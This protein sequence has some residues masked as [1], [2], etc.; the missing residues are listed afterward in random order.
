[1][2]HVTSRVHAPA[3]GK[4]AVRI[5]L[6]RRTLAK[7]RF[8]AA[9]EDGAEFGF[10]LPQPLKHGDFFHET[11]AKAYQ[12]LQAPE[13]TLRIVPEDLAQAA[14]YGWMIGNMHFPAAFETGA[15]LAEDDPAVRQM[16]ERA[17]IP[18]T[19]YEAIFQPPSR[20]A[21]HHH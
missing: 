10:D 15:I 19:E 2:R 1:M 14:L 6:D 4:K 13:T 16:L 5:R 17:H 12:I 20:S 21:H 9:A 8:R 3:K 7:R 11:D 18:Y